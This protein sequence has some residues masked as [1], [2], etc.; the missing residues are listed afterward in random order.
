MLETAATK[1]QI[2]EKPACHTVIRRCCGAGAATA[3][4]QR[5]MVNALL[6][7]T[8]LDLESQAFIEAVPPMT[9]VRDF[10]QWLDTAPANER[11]EAAGALARAYLC[12]D[13]TIDELA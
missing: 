7:T 9:I 8:A 4:R 12:S 5:F 3:D 2:A 1:R 6:R 11:A 10:L 13:L